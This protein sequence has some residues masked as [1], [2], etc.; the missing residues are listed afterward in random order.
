MY[1]GVS[2]R[3]GL[4][5]ALTTL[6]VASGLMLQGCSGEAER[7]PTAKGQ[8]NQVTESESRLLLQKGA[9]GAGKGF[10]APKSIKGRLGELGHGAG[11]GS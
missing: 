4:R 1:Q 5:K 11:P 7:S 9:K 10:G 2:A 8:I 3:Y 6:A